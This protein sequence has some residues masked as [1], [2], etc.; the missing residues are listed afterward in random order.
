MALPAM[1]EKYFENELPGAMKMLQQMVAVN[2]FTENRSGVLRLG[3]IT[4]TYFQQLGFQSEFVHSKTPQ[5]GDHL[6]M[7]HNG[8]SDCTI[9]MISHLDTVFSEEDCL[10][11][12]FAWSRKG[13]RIYG[14]GVVDIK[15]GTVLMHLVLSALRH[16]WPELFEQVHW[17]AH[18]NASEECLSSHFCEGVL[19]RLRGNTLACLVFESG[20]VRDKEFSLVESRKGR[21]VFRVYATGRAA[22]AG[23]N[24]DRGANAIRELARAIEKIE[25]MTDYKRDLTF[26]VGRI[27]GGA[28]AN[29]V[30]N[31]AEALVE[32]RAF[33]PEVLKKGI[34]EMMALDGTSTVKSASDGFASTLHVRKYSEVLPWPQNEMTKDLLQL[35]GKAAEMM[36]GSVLPTSRGGLSDGNM[37]A[38]KVP[39]LDGMGPSGANAH[40]AETSEDGSREAEYVDWSSMVPKAVL[41]TLAILRLLDRQQKL[42][43]WMPEIN[44]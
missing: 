39:T 35:Y 1:L 6:Y 40:C 33:D 38:L 17:L 13:D 42:K 30:P 7:H 44:A 27:E 4:A 8:R 3:Q 37:L 31:F 11:N 43:P 19:G 26:N 16:F 28:V 10:R 22:H 25:A 18:F 21:S 32:M 23:S 12:N 41:N 2:S 20:V 24:H 36:G 5:Y 14:P 9:C 34:E 15:G 29:G